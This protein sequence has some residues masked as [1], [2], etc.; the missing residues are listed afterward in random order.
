LLSS[1]DP[2]IRAI[3]VLAVC[4]GLYVLHGLIWPYTACPACQGGKHHYSPTGKNWRNCGKCGGS[5]KKTRLISRL[6][7][8]GD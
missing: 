4:V 6:L 8:R 3:V 1:L 2:T 7:G 5:G